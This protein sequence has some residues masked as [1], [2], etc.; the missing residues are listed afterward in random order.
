MVRCKLRQAWDREPSEQ[1]RGPSLW[2]GREGGRVEDQDDFQEEAAPGRQVGGG[3]ERA[4]AAAL[5]QRE[6]VL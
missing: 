6:P 1:G 4:D 5:I 3:G 2:P